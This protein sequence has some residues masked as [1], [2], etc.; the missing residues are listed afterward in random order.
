MLPH[1]HVP[2]RAV[3]HIPAICFLRTTSR[4]EPSGISRLYAS[5]GPRP[6]QSRPAYPG[7]MLPHDHVP[8]RAVRHIPAICFLMTTSRTEPS[9]I[10][11]RYASS[12]PR[13]GQSR[14]AYPGDML[15]QDHVPDRAVRHI[16]AICFLRTTS[17]TE[18]SGI[19]RLYA[20]SGPRPGQS[21]PAY[22]GDMLPQDHVPD[23]AVR[24]IPAICFLR[25]TSRTEPSGISRRYASSGPR[26]GQSRPAYPGYM[27]PQDH[28]PDRA[29]RHI[30]AICFLRTTS[31][32]E[33]SGI[34]RLYAS[35]GPRPGQSRPAYPGYMLP[36]DHVPDR[37]VRHIPAIC[38]LMTTSRT[39]PSGISR[40]Y[41]SS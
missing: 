1:D 7:Y 4:T 9:G 24:H 2:D 26:P 11:R 32:T 27:L 14:P 20:S 38:F 37:A 12:G 28:V 35:S 30:P 16:P 25:T 6:G 10:S 36:H 19:S 34:S 21:R 22:P 18:P 8:D 15:P 39:E 31:R 13:P 3:R 5:S 41:A 23:R 40:L 17:R 33:P 29:V